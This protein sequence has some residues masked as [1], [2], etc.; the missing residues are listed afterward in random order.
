[1][2]IVAT[3]HR[4]HPS[5]VAPPLGTGWC[6]CLCP[7]HGDET[8]SGAVH[9]EYDAFSCLACGVKGDA[10]ALIKKQEGVTHREAVTIA[11]TLL[12]GGDGEV[13]PVVQGQSSRRVFGESGSNSTG[14][15][16][17]TG[18]QSILPTRVRRRP[19]GGT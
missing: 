9:Y 7:F 14:D 11:Q 12:E 15:S 3:I 10:V 4:Y 16:G 1:M 13:P 8:P 18:R 5:W 6:R 2:P 19:F 17:R